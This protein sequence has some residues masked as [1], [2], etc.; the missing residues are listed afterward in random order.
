MEEVSRNPSERGDVWQQ[1]TNPIN[2]AIV[3]QSGN[4]QPSQ[5]ASASQ[6]QKIIDN[7]GSDSGTELNS[8][9]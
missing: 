5:T 7:G 3:T 8:V 6:S 9:E 1:L 2:Q 4:V